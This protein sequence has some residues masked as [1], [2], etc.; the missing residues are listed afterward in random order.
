MQPSKRHNNT[1]KKKNNNNSDDD[2]RCLNPGSKDSL[3]SLP[4]DCMPQKK[5]SWKKK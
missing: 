2:N 3:A 5:M 4:A 1:N